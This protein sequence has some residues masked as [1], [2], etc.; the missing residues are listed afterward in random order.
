MLNRMFMSLALLVLWACGGGGGGSQT[1]PPPPPAPVITQQPQSASVMRGGSAT[2]TVQA[3]N[4]T[5]YQWYRDD[6]QAGTGPV[7]SIARVEAPSTIHVVVSNSTASVRSENAYLT[8]RDSVVFTEQPQ[9]QSALLGQPVTFRVTAPDARGYQWKEN[10]L[11]EIPG[12][13]L[14]C[15]RFLYHPES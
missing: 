15:P 14:A 3:S 2:F 13:T 7:L 6:Q 5:H 8:V 1:P 10:G 12:A 11:I 9:D 4:A